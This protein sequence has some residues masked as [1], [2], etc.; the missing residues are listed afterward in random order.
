V[1]GR[2]L[3]PDLRRCPPRGGHLENGEAREI[4]VVIDLLAWTVDARKRYPNSNEKG[5]WHVWKWD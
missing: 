3:Q 4:P 1:L 5:D 2:A